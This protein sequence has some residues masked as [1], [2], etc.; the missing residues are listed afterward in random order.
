MHNHRDPWKEFLSSSDEGKAKESRR[1]EGE[2]FNVL[3]NILFIAILLYN[4]FHNIF[5]KLQTLIYTLEFAL[6]VKDIQNILLI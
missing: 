5:T 3:I 2:I 1:E 4:A 6:K